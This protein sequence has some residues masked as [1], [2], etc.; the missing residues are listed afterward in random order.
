VTPKAIEPDRSGK[1]HR[2]E[3]QTQPNAN[4]IWIE[5]VINIFAKS[6]DFNDLGTRHP[7]RECECHADLH[8]APRLAQH[9][10]FD[11]KIARLMATHAGSMVE[12]AHD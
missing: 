9:C 8:A 2:L 6:A 12:T 11:Q 3:V 4:S 1:R 5:D 7:T 10:G